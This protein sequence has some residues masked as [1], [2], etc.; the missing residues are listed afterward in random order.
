MLQ[1]LTHHVGFNSSTTR[2][3]LSTNLSFQHC[4]MYFL[5]HCWTPNVGLCHHTE[6][7][8]VLCSFY[9]CWSIPMGIHVSSTLL[10]ALCSP[11]CILMPASC[12]NMSSVTL[13]T[14]YYH[15]DCSS[16]LSSGPCHDSILG[17]YPW[18]PALSP[19]D[20]HPHPFPFTLPDFQ[21]H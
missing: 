16:Q 17:C 7:L 9:P 15:C 4:A 6:L 14:M 13:P 18:L 3:A 5:C 20:S 2:G 19:H 11:L 21:P 10:L 1:G 8:S 12:C